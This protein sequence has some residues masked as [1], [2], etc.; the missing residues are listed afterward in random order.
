M[1]FCCCLFQLPPLH[2]NE[3]NIGQ[4]SFA[5]KQ[6]IMKINEMVKY[7]R[8]NATTLYGG[9]LNVIFCGDLRQLEPVTEGAIQI[10]QEE[11]TEFH[12]A[13][14]TY[15]ELHGM[16]RYC[17]DLPW[18]KLLTRL[19]VRDGAMSDSDIDVVNTRVVTNDDELPAN[20]CDATHRNVDEPRLIAYG[21]FKKEY[22][23][24]HDIQEHDL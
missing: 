10:Y 4:I 9:G 12:G 20:I 19:L 6:D 11:F 2:R 8:D 23:N 16:H 22:C 7:L 18:G 24:Q 14:N 1:I 21:L 3:Q 15:I 17:F 5:S 13:I